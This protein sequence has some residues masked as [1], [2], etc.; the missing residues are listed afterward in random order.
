MRYKYADGNEKH[1][2]SPLD[3]GMERVGLKS[4]PR[5]VCRLNGWM[6]LDI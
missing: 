3:N 6:D 2:T 4:N 1:Y 5:S